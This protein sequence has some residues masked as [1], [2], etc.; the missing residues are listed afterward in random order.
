ML[1][2]RSTISEVLT[3]QVRKYRDKPLICFPGEQAS[4]GQVNA[5]SERLADSLRKI[6]VVHGDHAAIW[7]PNQLEWLYCLFATAKI[8]ATLVPL[9]TR[10][11]QAEVQYALQQSNAKA[12]FVTGEFQN[13]G[14]AE[15][16]QGLIPE[17]ASSAGEP[18]KPGQLPLLKS[19]ICFRGR[20]YRGMYDFSDLL[21]NASRNRPHAWDEAP[22]ASPDD[23]AVIMYT[24]GTTAFP[25]GAMMPH[26]SL[27]QNA[28]SIGSRWKVVETDRIFSPFPF[29]HGAGLT[30]SIL[31]AL[32]HGATLYSMRRW[33]TDAAVQL[34]EANKCTKYI[35]PFT[36]HADILDHPDLANY[37][38]SS[39][40]MA[41]A[42]HHDTIG[43]Q[44]HARL[45]W[46]ICG[47]YGLTESSPNVC[48]GD[49]DDPLET[50]LSTSGKPFD[51]LE[52]RIVDPQTSAD[53]LPGG[54]GE[55]Y[56][57]GWSVMRGYYNKP[58]ETADVIDSNGWLR[59]GDMGVMDDA[60]HLTF[61][62]RYKD[63]IKNG[64]ENIS[65]EEVEATLISHAKVHQAQVV[66]VPDRRKGEIPVAFIEVR[67]GFE[68]NEEELI[69]YCRRTLAG[70]KV[71]KSIYFVDE[72]PMTH[73][74]KIQKYE[75][76]RI[77][78]GIKVNSPGRWSSGGST[79]PPTTSQRA[80]K[81]NR[82]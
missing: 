77:A 35:G 19:V 56:V 34:I 14:H 23:T 60:G 61:R 43:R 59:T 66:G 70:F 69:D 4:Y 63:V 51:G 48:A 57:R 55:I 47:V 58:R 72:W 25:K 74:G 16:V 1:L 64:G 17:V 52:V 20:P 11:T 54:V 21:A 50:R 32:I 22:H 37:D 36:T 24:S 33:Q 38:L 62:G 41:Q 75:L 31:V 30:N 28:A 2:L 10:F 79:P 6:G 78:E 45:G 39:V 40:T 73:I 80:P 12:L 81:P 82:G 27:L 5:R 42:T 76:R 67:E 29:Y 3:E 9:N 68:A 7:M 53:L 15:I 13:I 46:Q 65:A 49:L 8:G 44:L 26:G 71:P 18:N